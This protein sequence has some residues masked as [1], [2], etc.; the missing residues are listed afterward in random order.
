MHTRTCECKR[1]STNTNC[2]EYSVFFVFIFVHLF[3]GF[4]F[5][6]AFACLARALLALSLSQPTKETYKNSATQNTHKH[7]H[8]H[9]QTEG[10]HI[11]TLSR[12]R[13]LQV[14]LF[15]SLAPARY[16]YIYNLRVCARENVGMYFTTMKKKPASSEIRFAALNFTFHSIFQCIFNYQTLNITLINTFH[17]IFTI[18]YDIFRVFYEISSAASERS[19]LQDVI[20]LRY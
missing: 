11:H 14:A 9:K 8:V 13:S 17:I 18:I 2:F 12:L 6:L 4:C 10:T 1:H 20:D 16:I 15:C 7:T 5:A 19:L 3:V